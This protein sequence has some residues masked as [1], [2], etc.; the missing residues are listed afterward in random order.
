MTEYRFGLFSFCDDVPLCFY[1]CC[2]PCV[3]NSSNLSKVRNEHWTVCHLLFPV[4]P[5]W[6]R[7]LVQENKHIP[8]QPEKDCLIT[9]FCVSCSVIQD[10]RE[11]RGY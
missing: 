10:A 6:T 8:S 5:Y 9:T 11:I 7:K 4:F 2:C 1:G 3:L